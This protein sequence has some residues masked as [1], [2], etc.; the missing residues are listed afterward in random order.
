MKNKEQHDKAWDFL[1]EKGLSMGEKIAVR[2]HFASMFAEEYPFI[3]QKKFRGGS[4]K[5]S[6]HSTYHDINYFHFDTEKEVI[7]ANAIYENIRHR[8]NS[9][10]FGQLLKFTFRLLGIENDWSK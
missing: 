2:S 10:E 6:Y 7:L 4:G 9:N 1:D 5:K 8:Y 3:N